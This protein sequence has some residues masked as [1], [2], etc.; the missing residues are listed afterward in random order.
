MA[1]ILKNAMTSVKLARQILSHCACYG[2][3]SNAWRILRLQLAF[4]DVGR[5]IWDRKPIAV[6]VC[7]KRLWI[8]QCTGDIVILR[9][10]F[11]R[12]EYSAVN[13]LT[14]PN[15]PIIV[16]LGANIGLASAFFSQRLPN[17]RIVAVEPDAENL[18]MV[19][20]NCSDLIESDRLRLVAGFVASADGEAGI[21]RGV[22]PMGYSKMDASGDSERIACYSMPKL[23]SQY[24][25]DR[26]DL[27]KCDIEGSER[28]L[29]H[30]CRSWIS[31]I[32]NMI[33]ETHGSYRPQHL[34]D[35]L[36]NNGATFRLLHEQ[37]REDFAVVL[38][39]QQAQA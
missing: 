25:L 11:E 32:S 7:E 4:S 13:R 12:M 19:R 6:A 39:S 33:V 23:I 3:W 1:S 37:R 30:D 20:R 35:D 29:F 17:S 22:E 31:R 21:K 16:D 18:S 10:I 9:D 27:L 36:A 28:E 2:G 5:R 26:I 15:E 34:L 24:D 14:L 38:L 8:R